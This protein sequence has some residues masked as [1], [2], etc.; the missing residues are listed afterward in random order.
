M[1]AQ[2]HRPMGPRGQMGGMNRAN[3]P[4]RMG[5]QRGGM[6]RMQ[7][8]PQQQQQQTTMPSQQVYMYICVVS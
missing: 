6:D 5:G 8:Q 4:Q 2:R 3:N 7:Q 1:H